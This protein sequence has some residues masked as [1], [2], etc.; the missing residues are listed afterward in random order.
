[1]N[2][3]EVVQID[4][5]IKLDELIVS[6]FWGHNIQIR[7]VINFDINHFLVAIGKIILIKFCLIAHNHFTGSLDQEFVSTCILIRCKT[8]MDHFDCSRRMCSL[9]APFFVQMHV[10]PAS[11][12][13]EFRHILLNSKDPL[14]WGG[15][16]SALEGRIPAIQSMIV[17]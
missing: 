7:D 17:R 2:L 3:L 5:V 11:K 12:R 8:Q 16:Q 1:M 6:W 13:S 4:R 9:P 15:P 14:M 10:S